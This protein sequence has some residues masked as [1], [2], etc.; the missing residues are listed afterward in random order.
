MGMEESVAVKLDRSKP[1]IANDNSKQ[2]NSKKISG[3]MIFTSTRIIQVD[4]FAH[5]EK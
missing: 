5:L 2:P 4:L 3:F 1:L